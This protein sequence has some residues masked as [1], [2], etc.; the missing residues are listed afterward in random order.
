[1]KTIATIGLAFCML[2][3]LLSAL[4]LLMMVGEWSKDYAGFI[5]TVAGFGL[6]VGVLGIR[7]LN[8]YLNGNKR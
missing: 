8:R 5:L 3:T 1:M 6:L 4:T 2:A 7:G